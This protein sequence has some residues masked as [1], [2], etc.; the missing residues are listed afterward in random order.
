MLWRPS[1]SETN[2]ALRCAYG[3][4]QSR[5]AITRGPGKLSHLLSVALLRGD[6]WIFGS[7]ADYERGATFV[8]LIRMNANLVFGNSGGYTGLCRGGRPC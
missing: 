6:S 5:L 2:D 7:E 8:E 4:D 3:W 1:S